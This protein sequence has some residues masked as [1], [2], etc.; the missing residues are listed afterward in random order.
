MTAVVAEGSTSK[1]PTIADC[2]IA[3]M[4]ETREDS[5]NADVAN[6]VQLTRSDEYSQ[7][8]VPFPSLILRY[9]WMEGSNLVV[10]IASLDPSRT[11]SAVKTP[12]DMMKANRKI[13][14]KDSNISG[15]Y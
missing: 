11:I 1:V 14:S 10:A 6:S 9:F 4:G 12:S 8:T 7:N 2:R 3:A 13:P 5:A 15:K